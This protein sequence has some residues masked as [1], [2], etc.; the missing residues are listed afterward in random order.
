MTALLRFDGASRRD[1]A[2]ERWLASRPGELGDIARTWFARIR[3]C[4]AGVR[5]LMHDGCPTACVGDA[6]LAYVNV[7][8]R[9]V[10]V[11]FF[12]G[13][14]LPD[15][16]GLLEGSGKYMRHV[17]LRPGVAC[18]AVALR[19]L[20]TAAHRDMVSRVAKER[21]GAGAA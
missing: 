20:I 2:V 1:P 4:G 14:S 11:G 13:A 9:H 19:A 6:G 16:G 5:E 21:K 15:P 3:A 8:T 7:Y 18:D 10:N 12:Q 17:K